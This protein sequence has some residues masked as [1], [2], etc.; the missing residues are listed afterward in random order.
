MSNLVQFIA[1]LGPRKGTALLKF[2]RQ[3][4]DKGRL[5][6]R[7]QLVQQCRM[8]PIEVINSSGFIKINTEALGD[9]E[10]YVE[11]LDGSR[12]HYEAYEWAKKMAVD[13]LEYDEDDGNL[14]NALEEILQEP[15]KLAELDLEAFAN[16]LERQGYGKRLN[17]LYDIRNELKDMYKDFREPYTEPTP[18]DTFNM[19]TKESPKTFFVGK[20]VMATVTGF[21]YKKVNKK[22]VIQFT[23]VGQKI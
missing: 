21:Q 8:G 19:V 18:E 14:G 7:T 6:N 4:K 16:E 1:G 2:M 17:T 12:I 22:F 23:V 9:S 13:A 20:L 10:V 3:S 5:E 11:A 15:E